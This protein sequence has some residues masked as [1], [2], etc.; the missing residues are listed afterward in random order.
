[1]KDPSRS[2]ERDITV[3][4]GDVV[5]LSPPASTTPRLHVVAS[6][7]SA[8][9]RTPALETS[10]NAAPFRPG[11]L[12]V[13]SWIVLDRA[14][15]E[16]VSAGAAA[17]RVPAELWLRLA[18]ESS[19]LAEEIAAY[20][21]RTRHWVV[22][23]LDVAAASAEHTDDDELR[24]DGL[25]R[26]ASL[27]SHPHA[28]AQVPERMPARLPEEMAGGWRRAATRAGVTLER[29]VADRLRSAPANCVEWEIAAALAC[30]TLAEWT[31][32]ASLRA[33]ATTM[34]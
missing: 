27:L 26:Y 15:Q 24:V 18:V 6:P 33:L 5:T 20:C 21:C 13:I 32:A 29:W 11:E 34:A 28:T 1:V 3:E 31:Y 14:S 4:L 25:A 9:L 16:R 2:E 30:Q 10:L 17:A 22:D 8:E 23:A 7:P 19:R 12:P